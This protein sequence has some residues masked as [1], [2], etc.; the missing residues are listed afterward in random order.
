MLRTEVTC[1]DPVV[2]EPD[3][4]M[5]LA[6]VGNQVIGELAAIYHHSIGEAIEDPQKVA[7]D[8][9]RQTTKRPLAREHDGHTEG[10]S[11]GHGK[12]ISRRVEGVHQFDPMVPEI[13]A[14]A[15]SRRQQLHRL[16][17]GSDR[18]RYD[19]NPLRP[20]FLIADPAW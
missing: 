4:P 2:T 1:I 11:D 18:K 7:I 20:Q 6:F 16:A 13:A 17:E 15:Q 19:R 3:L 10:P 14:H 5:R 8:R 9:A 12:K